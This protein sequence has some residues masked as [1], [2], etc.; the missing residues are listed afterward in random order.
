RVA[1]LYEVNLNTAALV[2]ASMDYIP[3]RME[4][5]QKEPFK[6][7]VDY[8][9]T[10]DSLEAVYKSLKPESGRLICILGAAGGGRDKWKRQEFGAIAERYCD[11]IF[12]TNEDP[13]EE[14]PEE[15]LNQVQ[16]GIQTDSKL[17]RILDRKEAISAALGAARTGDTV[18]ITGKGSETTMAVQGG[19]KI[20][21]SDKEAVLT[22]LG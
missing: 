7:V 20:P 19:K 11:E 21:W 9:H 18:V 16:K 2:L 1:S 12:L 3:G 6:V 17:H 4:V 8:A 15:I 10:P 13:Y 14:D 22:L 5:I